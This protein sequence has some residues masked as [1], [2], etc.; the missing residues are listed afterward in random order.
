MM[1]CP[2]QGDILRHKGCCCRNILKS[3]ATDM[4]LKNILH[5]AVNTKSPTTAATFC[6]SSHRWIP[7]RAFRCNAFCSFA[8]LAPSQDKMHPACKIFLPYTNVTKSQL[9]ELC[10]V[11]EHTVSKAQAYFRSFRKETCSCNSLE[12]AST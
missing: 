1:A 11:L 3:R 12:S 4:R 6:N 9:H 8:E 7:T 5:V 2:T 10:D